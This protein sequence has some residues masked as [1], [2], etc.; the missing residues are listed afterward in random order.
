VHQPKPHPLLGCESILVESDLTP[1]TPLRERGKGGAFPP[2]S[3]VGE[4]QGERLTRQYWDAIAFRW[5]ESDVH[6]LQKL[7]PLQIKALQLPI[8]GDR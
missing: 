2:L 1:P 4:G 5:G 8:K 7:E 3:R 6:I